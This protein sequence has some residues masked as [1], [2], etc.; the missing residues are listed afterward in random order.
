MPANGPLQIDTGSLSEIQVIREINFL[1]IHEAA[2]PNDPSPSFFSGG[3]LTSGLRQLLGSIV[4][5]DMVSV[6]EL[7]YGY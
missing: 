1:K 7:S 4:F 3:W 6:S 2:G 5:C